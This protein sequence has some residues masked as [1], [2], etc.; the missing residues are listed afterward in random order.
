MQLQIISRVLSP[1]PPPPLI[2]NSE[3]ACHSSSSSSTTLSHMAAIA[4]VPLG[5]VSDVNSV[6]PRK[7]SADVTAAVAGAGTSVRV[8]CVQV[9]A[10][11]WETL[12]WICVWSIGESARSIS[13]RWDRI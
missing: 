11:P 8:C 3:A 2:A 13:L 7:S 5:R 1:T 12:L 10:M 9:H 4:V 6:A